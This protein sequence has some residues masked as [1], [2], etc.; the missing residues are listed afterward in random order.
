MTGAISRKTFSTPSLD[1]MEQLTT[2]IQREWL[3]EIIARR[4]TVEYREI[5]P[6]WTERLEKV[7]RPFLL[8]LINGMTARA[9]EV[10]VQ[11]D[12]VRKNV[13]SG[14][15][16][17]HIGRV[18]EVRNW[19]KRGESPSLIKDQWRP[20]NRGRKIMPKRSWT[21]HWQIRSWKQE[22][23]PEGVPIRAAG[24]NMFRRRGVSP[25]DSVYIVSLSAG[26]LY[27][28]GRMTVKAIV[29]REEAIRITKDR[30]LF[31]A[32]EWLVDPDRDGTPLNLHRKLDAALAKRITLRSKHGPTPYKF[33]SD[34]ELDNQTTRG[35][36]E[37]TSESAE[38]LDRIIQFTD[39]RPKKKGVVTVTAGDV[40]V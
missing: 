16:E 25:G 13:A 36:R 32:A 26:E 15:Y 4:K 40:A 2:T 6:Y 11:I 34:T 31:Q 1:S 29:S 28:G 5:K 14:N 3:R 33:V 35:V 30:N 20:T 17:L 12:R 8:R 23:N 19:N 9:P 37:L 22:F 24:S 10:T 39:A 27:L 18:V 7:Q 21:F 38:M